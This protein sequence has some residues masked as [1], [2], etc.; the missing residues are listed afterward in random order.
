MDLC[1]IWPISAWITEVAV[2]GVAAFGSGERNCGHYWSDIGEC[3][4]VGG[5]SSDPWVEV[6]GQFPWREGD[7]DESGCGFLRLSVAGT[8]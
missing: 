4:G 8:G 6:G 5:R 3:R 7:R 1:K 2:S